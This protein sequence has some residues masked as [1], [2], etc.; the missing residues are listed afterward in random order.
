M[1]LQNQPT[2]LDEFAILEK[3]A[4]FRWLNFEINHIK[5]L[6]IHSDEFWI[7]E[8]ECSVS[9]LPLP[10]C[11][12]SNNKGLCELMHR[13]VRESYNQLASL[14]GVNTI[15]FVT[16]E[17]THTP[18]LLLPLMA[19][20]Q[21]YVEDLFQYLDA[22]LDKL[23]ALASKKIVPPCSVTLRTDYIDRVL[24]FM[25]SEQMEKIE[26]FFLLPPTSPSAARIVVTEAARLQP[27]FSKA[28]HPDQILAQFILARWVLRLINYFIN[29]GEAELNK[30]FD[31]RH[32]TGDTLDQRMEAEF[33][34]YKRQY[35][36]RAT[37]LGF[38]EYVPFTFDPKRK[39]K[40]LLPS[41]HDLFQ[42]LLRHHQN[43]DALTLL[44]TPSIPNE[45]TP[46]HIVASSSASGINCMQIINGLLA[47]IERGHIAEVADILLLK[48]KN[49]QLSGHP[50]VEH[51]HSRH[52]SKYFNM[53]SILLSQGY[54]TVVC[55]ILKAQDTQGNTLGH[56]FAL[57]KQSIIAGFIDYL[58][59]LN[60]LPEHEQK[61]IRGL[62]NRAGKTVWEALYLNPRLPMLALLK[63]IL[64]IPKTTGFQ[65]K[66]LAKTTYKK[67]LLLTEDFDL[68]KAVDMDGRTIFHSIADLREHRL[69]QLHL[70]RWHEF[71]KKEPGQIIDLLKIA[72]PTEG[73]IGYRIL[74]SLDNESILYLTRILFILIKKGFETD[75]DEILNA[76]APVLKS[77]NQMLAEK[78]NPEIQADYQILKHP[79]LRAIIKGDSV[80]HVG[81][82]LDSLPADEALMKKALLLAAIQGSGRT[83]LYL[84][85]KGVM[86]HAQDSD[87]N[88]A[89]HLALKHGKMKT[90]VA[91]KK[92]AKE[93]GED[94]IVLNKLGRP[95][96]VDVALGEHEAFF[97]QYEI[98]ERSPSLLSTP[99][100]TPSSCSS[101]LSTLT[102]SIPEPSP[103]KSS[104]SPPTAKVCQPKPLR[105]NGHIEALKQGVIDDQARIKTL[106]DQ[107]DRAEGSEEIGGL[108]KKAQ[109]AM[110]R[111]EANIKQIAEQSG[112]VVNLNETPIQYRLLEKM[113]SSAAAR[114]QEDKA[115]KPERA[116]AVDHRPD[117]RRALIP[118]PTVTK[119]ATHPSETR[120]LGSYFSEASAAGAGSG[121][122]LPEIPH[123][124]SIRFTAMGI[125][126]ILKELAK[127][128]DISPTFT[129]LMLG[130]YTS[131]LGCS[132]Y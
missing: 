6:L 122:G 83:C 119:S 97:R 39:Y 112:K 10:S 9:L 118:P 3:M 89:L 85:G 99:P 54:D 129:K 71:A 68:L 116:V 125:E 53:L 113:A 95:A 74:K 32:S 81:M 4:L 12:Y 42:I 128:T 17:I 8:M 62:M 51:Q 104:S 96:D 22:R 115:K 93:L 16:E 101:G 23:D 29:V 49:N 63:K 50:M 52:L 64:T 65:F 37:Q 109:A 61:Q 121:A 35:N 48:D 1:S 106:F 58:L 70:S 55:R 73:S 86:I 38:S 111:I 46:M 102:A 24:G 5:P 84:V 120:L 59:V 15:D 47:L 76:T 79:L 2:A 127:P 14:I 87:G 34:F 40:I 114:A 110:R 36:Q 66:C 92:K 41:R 107:K 25:F 43:S 28:T 117:Q 11:V 18:S 98:L 131:F 67:D 7:P 33:I 30:P 103:A 123:I 82:I 20:E 26:L 132:N 27:F 126:D 80:D 56:T 44:M 90:A 94:K 45:R 130:C 91:L 69:M 88:T 78:A 31:R 13:F 105:S 100:R 108:F 124:T 75:V 19:S 72:H 60:Q 77:L 21:K 57:S